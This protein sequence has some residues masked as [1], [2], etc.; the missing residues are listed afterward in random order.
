MI[1]TGDVEIGPD[2]FKNPPRI[3]RMT[4]LEKLCDDFISCA[5]S[6]NQADAVKLAKITKV[7]SEAL[8]GLSKF[9]ITFKF[10]AGLV[11]SGYSYLSES[12][13]NPAKEALRQAEEIAKS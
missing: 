6:A 13:C 9:E 2:E 12:I 11:T 7:L 10:E 5:K 3:T 1:E 4:E 8:E